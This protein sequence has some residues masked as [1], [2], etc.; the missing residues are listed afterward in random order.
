MAYIFVYFRLRICFNIYLPEIFIQLRKSH[1]NRQLDRIQKHGIAASANN[2]LSGAEL[3]VKHDID[4]LGEHSVL[5][6]KNILK[7]SRRDS[8]FSDY[9]KHGSLF[10]ALFY[11]HFHA[12]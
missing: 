4:K 6:A 11:E 10:I 2:A 1:L 7:C 5:G 3:I 8:R 9:I 12:G